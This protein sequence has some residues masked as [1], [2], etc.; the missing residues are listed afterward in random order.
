MGQ[1]LI[2]IGLSGLNAAQYGLSTTSNNISN[3]STPGYTREVTEYAEVNGQDT[4]SGF[5]GRGVSVTTVARQYSQYLTQQLNQATA[6]GGTLTSYNA[7]AESLSTIVGDPT[8]GLT[9]QLTTL[10]TG[11]QTVS[12][13]ASDPAS[14]AAAL[15]NMQ[16]LVSQFNT[17]TSQFNSVSAG[18]NT[19]LQGAV[20]SVNQLA[21]QI[22]SL[23]GQILTQQNTTGD[24]PNQLLDQRDAAVASL[25]QLIGATTTTNTNG[26][27]NVSI[28]NGQS[29]VNG[30]VSYQLATVPSATDPSELTIAY[31]VTGAG[32]TTTNIPIA[33]SNLSGGT[34]GGLLQFRSQI[35]DPQ[36]RALGNIAT[37]IGTTMNAQNEAGVTLTGAAGGP[38]FNV[39]Q[40]VIT[41]ATTNTGTGSLSAT[42]GGPTLSQLTGDDYTLSYDGT[43]FSLQDNTTGGAPVPVTFD[44]NGQANIDGMTLSMSSLAGVQ[45]GDSFQINA[46]TRQ[47]GTTMTMATT[48]PSAIAAG[49]P[50]ASATAGS[51]N[52]GTGA[53]TVNPP[54]GT[55]Y[56]GAL[57]TG[58][59]TATYSDATPPPTLTF[60]QGTAGDPTPSVTVTTAGVTTT[61]PP[62]TPVP[63]T[64][65]MTMT[66][67]GVSMTLSGTPVNGDTFSLVAN[68]GS[69]DNTN[70]L[71]MAAL[72]NA[73]TMGNTTFSGAYSSFVGAIGN[74]AQTSS[75][76]SAAQTTLIAQVTAAQQSVSGVNLD[77]EAT[78]L[79]T[80]EQMY[81]AN[82]KVIQ[83]AGTI[84]DSIIGI[85]T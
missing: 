84:F 73:N 74:A 85:T 81:Q 67:G 24:A 58:N 77:E 65:G 69:G 20:T 60:V 13:D 15:G 42:F 25:S 14:R 51:A 57:L 68:N 16:S 61:Y 40:P 50:S 72:M 71:A 47:A 11:L 10:Y 17:L 59:V 79:L 26:S 39:S 37:T 35:L 63:Y 82:S 8:A 54:P 22:A 3:A 52:T 27:I 21:S 23:N 36:Q 53:I 34:L 30:N 80:Y 41:P 49:S 32:G 4:G 6:Q 56:Q 12:S 62:G 31:A 64:A 5:L 38:L 83:A 9:T 70:V 48:D 45:A 19:Q 18:V 75:T 46:D 29:L 28:G 33:E 44:A 78:N 66:V 76:A 2:D 7:Q 1:S 55:D 43:N